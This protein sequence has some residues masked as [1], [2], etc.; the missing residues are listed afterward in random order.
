MD[1]PMGSAMAG[2]PNAQEA[3]Q[4]A[5]QARQGQGAPVP[6]LSQTGQGTPA[7]PPPTPTTQAIPQGVPQPTGSPTMAQPTSE[8]ELIVKAL[9]SRLQSISSLEKSEVEGISAPVG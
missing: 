8:A 9:S 7:M 1:I 4:A 6:Q 3:L 2:Q 5:F